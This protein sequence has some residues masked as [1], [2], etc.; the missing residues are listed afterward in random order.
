MS[1]L[2][3]IDASLAAMWAIPET[4]SNQAL[5]LVNHRAQEHTRLIAPV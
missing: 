5:A 3:V 1:K 2:V 4:Y